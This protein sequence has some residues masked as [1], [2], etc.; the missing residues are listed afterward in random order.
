MTADIVNL[1]K[2]RKAKARRDKE[3]HAAEN[4]AT[5]G[6]TKGQKQLEALDQARA[7]KTLD[8]AKR[9]DAKRDD[10]KRDDTERDGRD[11]A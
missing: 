5:F 4:R 6:R 3:L 10:A 2:A 11:E 8:D 7:A 1:R 9:D